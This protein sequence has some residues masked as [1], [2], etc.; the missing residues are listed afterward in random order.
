MTLADGCGCGKVRYE[1]NANPIVVNCC[2]CHWCQ[3]ETGSAFAHNAV[4]ETNRIDRQGVA[5][6]MVSTPTASGRGQT[7][8]RC[9]I[10]KVAVWSHYGPATQAAFVR[11]GTLDDPSSCPPSVHVFTDNKQPWVVLPTDAETFRQFY[12]AD[13]AKRIFDEATGARWQA[14]WAQPAG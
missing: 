12:G 14:M 5:P 10:C 3:R 8:A 11:V 9:P 2:H 13:D 7:I 1:L 4:I 6:E